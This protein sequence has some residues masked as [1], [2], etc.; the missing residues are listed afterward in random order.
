MP[1]L[2]NDGSPFTTEHAPSIG[3]TPKMLRLRLDQGLLRREFRNVYVDAAV[4]DSRRTRLRALALV[5]PDNAIVCDETAAWVRGLDVF[6]PGRRRDLAPSMLVRHG[7]ARVERPGSSGRQ[8]I[9]DPDDVEYVDGLFVTTPLRTASDL[10]RRMYRP[11]ALA[12][13]DAFAHAG[14]IDVDEM[15]DYVAR[16]KGYRGIVQARSL[17]AV[18]D[19]RTQA[20]GESWQ[21]LR[22]LDAGLPPPTPQF[23]VVDD[24]GRSYF[25]D[26]PYPDVLVGT[27]YDGREFHTDDRHRQHDRERRTYLSDLYGWRWVIGTRERIFGDDVSFRA[28]AGDAAGHHAVGAPVGHTPPARGGNP[29]VEGRQPPPRRHWVRR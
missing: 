20:P 26:L 2:I 22:I 10:L 23:E 18:V 14:L 19:A 17:A 25:I 6:A 27:E 16:L 8:A 3:L 12:A 5:T 28:R 4:P 1:E 29:L 15:I 13:A 9:I 7:T 21:R 11:Y 24:F